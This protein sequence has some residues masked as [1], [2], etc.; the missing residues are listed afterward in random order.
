MGFVEKDVSI[1]MRASSGPKPLF[2]GV[3][4]VRLLVSV[5]KIPCSVKSL[6]RMMIFG[7]EVRAS[8]RKGIASRS[9]AVISI[10]L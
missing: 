6:F 10:R 4:S 9:A 1:I 3:S 2:R 5:L 7:I 8:V